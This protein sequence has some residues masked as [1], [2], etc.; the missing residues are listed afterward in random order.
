MSAS[1]RGQAGV[2]AG[3]SRL[4]YPQPT[5][6]TTMTNLK[7]MV[8]LALICAGCAT[9]YAEVPPESPHA[10]ITFQ[11]NRDAVKAVN[12]E[13][14]QG[15]DVMDNGRCE[16]RQGV[17]TFSFDNEFLRTARFSADKKLHFQMHSVPD[18]NI[19]GPW[20]WSYLGFDAQNGRD[21]VVMHEACTP[22]VFDKT[23]GD[24]R[25]VE[26]IDVIDGFEC[27]NS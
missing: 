24:W 9:R 22:K 21:Y 26:D 23:D 16:N 8:A 14:M 13:P 15:Y 10:T 20:C 17:A 25:P 5:G 7:W 1:G 19:N 27:P 2:I 3:I 18:Q 11:R 4:I 12:L 6:R